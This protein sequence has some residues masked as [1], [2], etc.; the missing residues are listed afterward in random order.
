MEDQNTGTQ[1]GTQEVD[2]KAEAERLKAE[3]EQKD[4][5]ITDLNKAVSSERQKRKEVKDEDDTDLESRLL[6]KLRLATAE[7]TVQDTLKTLADSDEDRAKILETYKNRMVATGL[8]K[9][10]IV[11]DLQD[12]KLLALKD[13]AFAEAEKKARKS[14]AEKSAMQ[15]S[16]ANIS[17]DRSEEEQSEQ[18]LSDSERRFAQAMKSQIKK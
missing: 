17:S 10:D 13:K 4:A 1:E 5:K 2:W 8:S 9:E 14:F 12:A 7:D 16:N 15:N 3:A 6:K 11:R 18:N